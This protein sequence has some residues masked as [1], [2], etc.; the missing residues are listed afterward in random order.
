MHLIFL[1]YSL[2][3]QLLFLLVGQGAF[4][5]LL[6][7][8]LELLHRFFNGSLNGLFGGHCRSKMGRISRLPLDYEDGMT[9]GMLSS[10]IAHKHTIDPI[11][12]IVF[13]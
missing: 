2:V 9:C 10:S 1:L 5:R 8:S 4:M 7:N 11:Q 12:I 3:L 6:A 13:S